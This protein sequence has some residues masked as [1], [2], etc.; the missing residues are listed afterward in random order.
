MIMYSHGQS[1]RMIRSI[2]LLLYLFDC[3]L[4]KFEAASPRHLISRS[5]L[6]RNFRLSIPLSAMVYLDPKSTTTLMQPRNEYIFKPE[7]SGRRVKT[8]GCGSTACPN[9]GSYFPPK[10]QS[11]SRLVL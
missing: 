9:S 10:E 7:S 11:H 1:L 6:T 5:Q 8:S 2:L 3:C 4:K